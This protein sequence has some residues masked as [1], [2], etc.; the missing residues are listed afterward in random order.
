MANIPKGKTG[1]F[2]WGCLTLMV[3]FSLG[4]G[5]VGFIVYQ[6]YNLIRPYTAETPLEV[7]VEEVDSEQLEATR[8]RI[9]EF[10]LAIQKTNPQN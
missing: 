1:C 8:S 10:Q 6:T 4:G 5:C 9:R 7:P 2:F 3:L